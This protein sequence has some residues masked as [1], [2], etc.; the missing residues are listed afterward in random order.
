MPYAVAVVA[1]AV[2]GEGIKANGARK[3]AK[4]Q[5][6]GIKAA[7]DDVNTSYDK[8]QTYQ[9]P[10]VEAG[11]QTLGQ[12]TEGL[13]AGGEFNRN[14]SEADFKVDPGYAFRQSEG[15]KAVDQGATARGGVLSGAALKGEQRFGQDLASQ[16]Y[17]SAYTRFNND[18]NTRFSRLNSLAD[19]GQHAADVSSGAER[20][21]GTILGNLSINKGNVL[22]AKETAYANAGSN[23]V[24]AIGS[25]ISGMGGGSM[26]SVAGGG[27]AGATEAG[28]TGTDYQ[29]W[30]KN[31][32]GGSTSYGK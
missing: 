16:E 13:K 26:G 15:L 29:N 20:E 31:Q 24:N 14:F 9:D 8:A 22:A 19:R 3:A 10:Y 18:M 17:Q 28:Y 5:V 4:A 27:G 12:L 6:K 2:I 7:K 1:A 21:R 25:G 30:V 23:A 11:K 32:S